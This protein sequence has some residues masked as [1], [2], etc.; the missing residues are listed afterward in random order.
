M[1]V[2]ISGGGTG[3][4]IYPAISIAQALKRRDYSIEILFVGARG[5]MEMEKVPES[6]FPIVGIDIVGLKRSF[7]LSNFLLPFKIW[8]SLRQARTILNEFQPDLVIGVGGYASGPLLKVASG[9]KIPIFLQEQNSHAGLTN[10]LLG[11][12]AEKIFVAFEGMDKFFPASKIIK[13]GN[14]VRKDILN[15]EEKKEEGYQYFS[16]DPKRKTILI[17]GGS[18]GAKALNDIAL[19]AYESL[20][21]HLEIQLLWQTGAFYFERLKSHSLSQLE[22][23]KQLSFIDRMDLAYAVAD[24]VICRAG[25]LTLSELALAGK[26]AILVPSPYVAEDHQTKNARSLVNKEAAMMIEEKNS[27]SEVFGQA[28]DLLKDNDWRQ[29]LGGN[30]AQLA[31]PNADEKIVNEVLKYFELKKNV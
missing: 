21:E 3:G 25:A 24:V 28:L 13:S 14:P 15:L 16:L 1:R 23:V 8:K 18:L 26:A 9:M 19:S 22:N 27:G 5:K 31:K 7:S 17:F 4:H 2:I 12:K 30:I 29:K 6:G 10:R 20:K 11:K